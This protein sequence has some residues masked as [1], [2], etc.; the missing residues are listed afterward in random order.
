MEGSSF[1]GD[2]KRWM[3]GTLGVEHLSLKGLFE[4]NLE[5]D[6]ITGDPGGYAEKALETGISFHRGS[7]TGDIER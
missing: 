2:F 3:K 1:T 5:G 6:F 7:C 4:G